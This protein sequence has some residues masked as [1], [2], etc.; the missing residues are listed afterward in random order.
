MNK[1][2]MPPRAKRLVWV[3][4]AQ[5]AP[6]QQGETSEKTGCIPAEGDVKPPESKPNKESKPPDYVGKDVDTRKFDILDIPQNVVDS[7]KE[8]EI[9][10]SDEQ[11]EVVQ[12]Y[13][14]TLY[15]ELND[16]MQ[17]CPPKFDCVKGENKKYMKLIA[18]AIESA[19]E[20]EKPVPVYRGM[21][22]P[23][24]VAEKLIAK[25]RESIGSGGTFT[26][27][28]F[29]STS[30]DPYVALT[31]SAG[32]NNPVFF[33]VMAKKGMYV[34]PVTEHKGEHEVILSTKTKYKV[35]GV[36][37]A[38][39]IGDAGTDRYPVIYLEEA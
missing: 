34:E 33:H 10:L 27:P 2:L 31:S 1:R 15:A 32:D 13:T 9:S 36:S 23:A 6:C 18:S 28:S 20:F 39:F 25:S 35:V 29:I 7:G 11:L 3:V 37:E 12:R 17:K 21:N 8:V 5:G 4:K 14:Q 30:L 24:E 16:A 38:N 26:M 19:P 22:V